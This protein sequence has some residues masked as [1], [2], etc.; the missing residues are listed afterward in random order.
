M[1]DS[2]EIRDL[3]AGYFRAFTVGDPGWVEMHV[4]AG[5]ELR[6]IGTNAEEWL[7]GP[8]GFQRFR[9]EAAAASGTLAAELSDVE[10][11]SASDVGWGA[12]R[13]RFVTEDGSSAR[14]RFSVVFERR[15]RVWVM[16]ASHTSVPVADE[17][18]FSSG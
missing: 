7:G 6:L 2:P 14:A 8:V 13:I 3:I 15:D 9:A 11:Y 12:A 5:D 18:V 4:S 1:Q 10:G 16:V 17:D